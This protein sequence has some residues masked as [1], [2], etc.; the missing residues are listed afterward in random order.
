MTFSSR[1]SLILA[2]TSGGLISLLAY[3]ASPDSRLPWLADV[4]LPMIQTGRLSAVWLLPGCMLGLWT[5][6][7]ASVWFGICVGGWVL[8]AASVARHE[9]AA[10]LPQATVIHD[11]L[12]GWPVVMLFVFY[13]F[14]FFF[15]IVDRNEYLRYR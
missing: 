10:D 3:F 8:S 7:W 1:T 6:R 2:V 4:I 11:V 13:T 12:R 14:F 9:L 5:D 15:R